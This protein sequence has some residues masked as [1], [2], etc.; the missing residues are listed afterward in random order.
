MPNAALTT[1][2]IEQCKGW[3]GYPQVT[4]AANPIIGTSRIFE[5]VLQQY[6]GDQLIGWIRNYF[7]VN[8]TQLDTDIFSARTRYQA[9][10]L[11][12]EVKL[13][14]QEHGRLV[15]LRDWMVGQF[16]EKTGIKRYKGGRTHNDTAEV[17]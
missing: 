4:I 16:E 9:D 1:A 14:K 7:I 3:L 15:N 17:F 5:D 10:E 8:M 6:A 12:G 13:N 2:E 11:V